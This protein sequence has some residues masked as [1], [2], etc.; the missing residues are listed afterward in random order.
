MTD[1][2]CQKCE[3]A[4]Y[5]RSNKKFCS[6]KCRKL[7]S[8]QTIRTTTP[9]NSKNS[10]CKKREQYELFDTALR[11]AEILYTLPPSE[12]LGFMEHLI[13]MA[14]SGEHPK[15]KQILK[16]PTLLKANSENE[17]LFW[18]HAAA[19]HR[20]ILQAANNYCERFW[21]RN[22]IFVMNNLDYEPNTGEVI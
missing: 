22:V 5:G 18:R 20:T 3:K 1:K 14:R 6:S 4:F 2:H 15:L 21:K 12:R 17:L 19:N 9:V 13:L 8:Q 16:M 10:K 11:L 7:S